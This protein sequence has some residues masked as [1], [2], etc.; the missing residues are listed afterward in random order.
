MYFLRPIVF[1]FGLFFFLMA[2]QYFQYLIRTETG[3][4]VE[5]DSLD[6]RVKTC[7]SKSDI[8]CL[9]KRILVSVKSSNFPQVTHIRENRISSIDKIGS[10][11]AKIGD[12][13]IRN[14]IKADEIE[15]LL[16]NVTSFDSLVLIESKKNADAYYKRYV[17]SSSAADTFSV[18]ASSN[19]SVSIS[20]PS[21]GPPPPVP[22]LFS[23]SLMPLFDSIIYFFRRIYLLAESGNGYCFLKAFL[24]NSLLIIT[25]KMWQLYSCNIIR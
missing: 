14:D 12:K 25:I 4:N 6:A 5:E 18:G 9:R 11:V 24:A 20:T 13:F 3:E 21:F 23:N 17:L 15:T 2:S 22:K 7:V 1:V 10:Y 16:K 19:S 8:F